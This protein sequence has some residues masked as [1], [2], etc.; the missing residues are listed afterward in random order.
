MKTYYEILGIKKNANTQEVK[1]SFHKLALK[2]HPDKVSQRGGSEAELE[3]TAATFRHIKA[4]YETLSDTERR[5]AYNENYNGEDEEA[6]VY[7]MPIPPGLER[8][9][10]VWKHVKEMYFKQASLTLQ[11]KKSLPKI[12]TDELGAVLEKANPLSSDHF[13]SLQYQNFYVLTSQDEAGED[14]SEQFSDVFAFIQEKVRRFPDDASLPT[15]EESKLT[16]SVALAQFLDFLKG[17]Y[18]GSKLVRFQARLKTE[19]NTYTTASKLYDAILKFV[20][21]TDLKTEYKTAL[22]AIHALSD[23]AFEQYQSVERKLAL[24]A[25]V[26]AISEKDRVGRASRPGPPTPPYKRFRIRRFQLSL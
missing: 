13:S 21:I 19:V 16:P 22:S 12:T 15:Q 26:E 5:A 9:S 24:L 11:E 25:K 2:F 17:K 6:V 14:V 10:A 7:P 1:A 3:A 18:Y 4:A 20:S 8:P 23:A